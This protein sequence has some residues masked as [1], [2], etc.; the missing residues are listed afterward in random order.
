MYV[1][2][3]H[4]LPRWTYFLKRKLGFC[5]LIELN[6][7][8]SFYWITNKYVKSTQFVNGINKWNLEERKKRD[9]ILKI[10]P[11]LRIR[12]ASR[13]WTNQFNSSPL[14]G[15]WVGTRRNF[16]WLRGRQDRHCVHLRV[17][18][19]S[20]A[21]SFQATFKLPVVPLETRIRDDQVIASGVRSVVDPGK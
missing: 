7:N 1:Q 2:K 19:L 14:G 6:T 20:A 8:S 16:R 17:Q 12:A 15:Y 3:S 4:L 13:R 5:A 18:V 11:Y 21:G 10:L 9:K